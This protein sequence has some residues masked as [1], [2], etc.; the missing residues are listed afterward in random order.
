MLS[1]KRFLYT[2][3]F[4]WLSK[5]ELSFINRRSNVLCLLYFRKDLSYALISSQIL[6]Y[7]IETKTQGRNEF[8]TLNGQEILSVGHHFLQPK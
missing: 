2:I 4:Y 7:V 6:V 8:P 1:Q 5:E 3:T